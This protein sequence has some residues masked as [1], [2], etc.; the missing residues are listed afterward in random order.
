MKIKK[1]FMFLIM[2]LLFT[3]CESGFDDMMDGANNSR[4]VLKSV[5]VSTGSINPEFKQSLVSYTLRQDVAVTSFTLMAVP[6]NS[7]STMKYRFDNGIWA[8]L[9]GSATITGPSGNNNFSKLIEIEVTS[10]D[11]LGVIVYSFNVTAIPVFK[12]T[13]NIGTGN[14]SGSVPVD[15][16]SYTTNGTVTVL[17]NTGNLIGAAIVSGI[18]QR[19]LG[20]NTDSSGTAAQY[21]AGSTFVIAGDV[22]LYAVYTT[23]TDVLRKVG[24]ASGLVFHDNTT[25]TGSPSWRYLE[26]SPVDISGKFYWHLP[27][28]SNVM[29]SFDIGT[30][31]A[32]TYS[33][34]TGTAYP[35][36]E[37]CRTYSFG[38][39]SSGWFLPS[40]DELQ[41][42]YQ[43]LYLYGLGGFIDAANEL[44][45]SSSELDQYYPTSLWMELQSF[46]TGVSL[47]GKRTG[48]KPDPYRVRAVRAF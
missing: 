17:A 12:V 29:T 38:G 7:D 9:S 8:T 41:Q 39:I 42:M 37:A 3:S 31:Y 1:M 40:K 13:Y 22:T 21:I 34:M 28:Q 14:S 11:G 20:W 36:A 30:G 43:V 18:R 32:N 6:E 27:A 33:K 47:N 4:A 44:Y 19:F 48:N 46:E 23:G 24:P 35:A 2:A 25:Y 15:G 16:N 26:A 10:G 45:L 5:T